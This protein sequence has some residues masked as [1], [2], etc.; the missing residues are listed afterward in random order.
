MAFCTHPKRHVSEN[1]LLLLELHHG[2]RSVSANCQDAKIAGGDCERAAAAACVFLGPAPQCDWS[3]Q[4][5]CLLRSSLATASIAR[6]EFT[7]AQ[8]S[9]PRPVGC[10]VIMMLWLESAPARRQCCTATRPP[11]SLL[12]RSLTHTQAHTPLALN[13]SAN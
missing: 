2:E 9:N 5:L 4:I 8:V 12:F 6:A 11:A 7:R 1:N 13:N 10:N 3:S